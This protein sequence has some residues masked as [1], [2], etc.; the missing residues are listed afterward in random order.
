MRHQKAGRHLGRTSSHRVALRRNLAQALFTHS[1][2]IT[3]VA[4]A[5]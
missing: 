3:T 2:I 4:K 1:R 5:K